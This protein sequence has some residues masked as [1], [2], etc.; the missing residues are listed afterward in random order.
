LHYLGFF[1]RTVLLIVTRVFNGFVHMPQEIILASGSEI[2]AKMLVSAGVTH[3]IE[4]PRIDE[5]AVRDALAAED[6]SPRDMADTLAELKARKISDRMPDALVIG[7]DQVLAFERTVLGKP[8]DRGQVLEHLKL[9]RGQTHMLLSAAV[10]CEGGQPVWRHVGQARLTMRALSD[11]FL[12]T[13][14][15]RNWDSIC[16]SVGGYKLE[17]EGVRL[18]TRIEGDHFTILGLPLL[19][20]LN[21]L[22]LKGVLAS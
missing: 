2:R 7:C 21:H 10:I 20:L 11:E 12:E 19:E 3:R 16:H 1:P 4:R 5:A 14:I 13:Y 8:D 17:E 15:D 18:F 22:T 9:L 6:A